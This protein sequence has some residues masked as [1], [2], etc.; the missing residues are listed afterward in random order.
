[1]LFRSDTAVAAIFYPV[2]LTTSLM[3][4]VPPEAFMI[5]LM[6]ASSTCFA[7]PIGTPSNR[8]VY[9]EGGYHAYDYLPIGILMKV[10]MLAVN[11]TVVS[12]M[13]DL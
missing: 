1:M 12:L 13:Y 10:V 3:M 8:L 11:I 7:T 9:S 5:S 6:L 2:A 4:R